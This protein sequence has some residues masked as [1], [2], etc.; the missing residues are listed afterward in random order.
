MEPLRILLVD[1]HILFR[2]GLAS[3]LASRPGLQ[4]VGEAGDGLEAIAR[5]RETA[6]DLILMDIGMPNCNGLEVWCA[7]ISA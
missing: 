4:V 3:L 2:K 7:G 5:A 6:P 1:D